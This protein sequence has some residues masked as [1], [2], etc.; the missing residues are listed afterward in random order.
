MDRLEMNEVLQ[1]LLDKEV[2]RRVYIDGR[3]EAVPPIEAV[4][5]EEEGDVVWRPIS[6]KIL[7]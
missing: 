1:Y 2:A 6:G 5:V 7:A 3:D 4:G